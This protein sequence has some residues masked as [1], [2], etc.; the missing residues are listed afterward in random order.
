MEGKEESSHPGRGEGRRTGEARD[1]QDDRTASPL[2]PS[3]PPTCRRPGP[4]TFV[5]LYAETKDAGT[6]TRTPVPTP[7]SA[8]LRPRAGF[9]S[10]LSP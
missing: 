1:F 8:C 3:G 9:R 6:A 2:L 5:P 4:T 7:V 10:L